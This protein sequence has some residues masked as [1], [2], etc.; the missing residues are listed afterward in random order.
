MDYT[1]YNTDPYQMDPN[2]YYA[3]QPQQTAALMAFFMAYWIM[4]LAV[5]VIVVVGLWK[6]FVKAGHPGWAALIP[7][8]NIYVLLKIVGKPGWWLILYLI[9]LVQIVVQ[10]IVALRLAKAFGKT[11][12]FG[13]FLLWLLAPI[14]Y[15]ILGFG[16][17]KY[18]KSAATK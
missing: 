8:Y 9:P 10:I 4:I 3:T 16:S 15:L 1:Q 5:Y 18:N 11:D 2:M 12:V 13:I 17:A 7:F 6:T 14:G